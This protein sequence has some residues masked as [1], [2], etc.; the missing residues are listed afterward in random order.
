MLGV[1]CADNVL[2][3]TKVQLSSSTSC[4]HLV[5][6]HTESAQT[7]CCLVPKSSLLPVHLVAMHLV[8]YR[9]CLQN[10][11]LTCPE[12]YQLAG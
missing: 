6:L 12:L 4:L 10:V 8:P 2:F 11:C 9:I 3:G 5:P 1:E 7:M